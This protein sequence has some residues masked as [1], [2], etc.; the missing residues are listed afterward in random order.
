M[1]FVMVLIFLNSSLLGQGSCWKPPPA[2]LRR[3]DDAFSRMKLDLMLSAEDNVQVV[4]PTTPA[5]FFHVLRRQV[6][7]RW[8]KP[9]I[10]FT[11]KSLLPEA[12]GHAGV[13]FGALVDRLVRR[14]K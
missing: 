4:V 3:L 12:A 10:V 6:L 11:P 13:N 7:R 14:P 9:L 8:R 1:R 5:Q 2:A